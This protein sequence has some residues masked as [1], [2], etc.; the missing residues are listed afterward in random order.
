MKIK[1][2]ENR[3]QIEKVK[4]KKIHVHISTLDEV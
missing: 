3:E 2:T 4:K 1:N